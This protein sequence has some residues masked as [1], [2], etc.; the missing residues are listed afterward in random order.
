MGRCDGPI[1]L[2]L[3]ASK[4]RDNYSSPLDADDLAVFLRRIYLSFSFQ[5]PLTA[6]AVKAMKNASISRRSQSISDTH[7]TNQCLA[8]PLHPSPAC[9]YLI[10]VNPSFV[11]NARLGQHILGPLV[12]YVRS[13]QGYPYPKTRLRGLST[14][15][16]DN[17]TAASPTE[18]Q[19]AD[20]ICAACHANSV[21]EGIYQW[22]SNCFPVR[23]GPLTK[24]RRQLPHS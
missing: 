3:V 18:A 17:G 20:L 15:S 16:L 24:S 14:L 1:E 8:S 7:C 6:H 22:P 12:L 21:D 11:S 10:P 19:C 9:L 13:R 4:L 2:G 5:T 23:Y